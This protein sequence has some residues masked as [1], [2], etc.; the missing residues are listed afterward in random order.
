MA[1]IAVNRPATAKKKVARKA[2]AAPKKAVRR[3]AAA[4]RKNDP[5]TDMLREAHENMAGLHEIGLIDKQTMAEFDEMCLPKVEVLSAADIRRLRDELKLSQ[6][7]FALYLNTTTST[8]SKW[9][10][11]DKKPNGIAQRLLNIVRDKGLEVIR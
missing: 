1:Q 7:V 11:G 4:R 9:E 6:S 3:R 8:V 5:S 2:K 10:Q